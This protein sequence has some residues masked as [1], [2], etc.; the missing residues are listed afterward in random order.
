MS[1]KDATRGSSIGF[2]ACVNSGSSRPSAQSSIIDVSQGRV[3]I[4]T[5][6]SEG[7]EFS[8][9][10]AYGK[11]YSVHDLYDGSVARIVKTLA[12]GR[13]A[14]ILALGSSSSEKTSMV[15]RLLPQIV[16]GLYAKMEERRNQSSSSQPTRRDRRRG[17]SGASRC[18]MR[19]SAIE[20]NDEVIQD[21]LSTSN[22]ELITTLD[23]TFGRV[24][25]NVTQQGPTS[26]TDEIMESVTEATRARS[27]GH[28]V[29]RIDVLLE[30]GRADSES[31]TSFRV[32]LLVCD[33]AGTEKLVED[34]STLRLKE[35]VRLNKSLFALSNV[36]DIMADGGADSAPCRE[37]KLTHVI[38]EALGGNFDTTCIAFLDSGQYHESLATMQLGSTLHRSVTYPICNNAAAQG[39]LRRYR[40][41]LS[42]KGAD[43][44]I[45]GNYEESEFN[46]KLSELEGKAVKDKLEILKLREDKSRIVEKLKDFQDRYK[47]LNDSKR[48]VQR[49]LIDSEEENL[50]TSNALLDMQIENNQLVERSEAEKYELLSKIMNAENEILELVSKEQKR[51]EGAEK[52]KNQYETLEQQKIG[53]QQDFLALQANF[54]RVDQDLKAE[55]KKNEELGL[56]LLTLV[57]QRNALSTECE[58]LKK[59]KQAFESE[60]EKL[61]G[62]FTSRQDE[63]AEVKRK[64]KEE[65][66]V[67]ETLRSEKIKA[68]LELQ[69][70]M[71]EYDSKKLEL[72]KNA[73]DFTR[74]RDSE[75]VGL[76]KAV[77]VEG[78]K[79]EA[80]RESLHKEV[81][82]LKAGSRKLSRTIDTLQSKLAGR[83]AELNRLVGE[84][85]ELEQKLKGITEDYQSKLIQYMNDPANSGDG[86]EFDDTEQRRLR[87]DLVQSFKRQQAE[88]EAKSQVLHGENQSLIAKN[89]ALV[90]RA[91]E[92]RNMLEDNNVKVQNE[93][94]VD[95]LK[96]G[97]GEAE[98]EWQRE[99]S[100]LIEKLRR[101]E[102]DLTL[103]KEKVIA[104]AEQGRRMVKGL[105][106]KNQELRRDMKLLEKSKQALEQDNEMLALNRGGGGT[107]I[108]LKTVR[109]L[110]AMMSEM[111]TSMRTPN[112]SEER[113]VLGLK[114]KLR[115][116]ELEIESL[117]RMGGGGAAIP[118]GEGA[119]QKRIAELLSQNAVL[120]GELEHYEKYMKNEV[121]KMKRV[122]RE[123][124]FWRQ[125]AIQLGATGAE[126]AQ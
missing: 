96:V 13:S 79:G 77:E 21:L 46:L 88:L 60:N 37:S 22:R 71:I 65:R 121:E 25:R 63:L 11:G 35:G 57:N 9:N 18:S 106:N 50:K 48:S 107:G 23:E 2:V 52:L 105:E 17:R 27:S 43:G 84:N 34:P 89:R 40:R 53:L 56:E 83:T 94:D 67:S 39:L 5:P 14:C 112:G 44:D 113:E 16:R 109:E 69:R 6:S 85:A 92:L 38:E 101:A 74:D 117:R 91:K 3:V 66:G 4:R 98:T 75:V 93:V 126:F 125:K 119:S 118:G 108:P 86:G 30:L 97:V 19:F 82:Q 28:A 124:E 90:E 110:Q 111:K 116:A 120:K 78:K 55:L 54:V 51:D 41:K 47:D 115:Q 45:D 1:D 42:Q 32:S 15:H 73:S 64:L 10:E 81:K 33:V 8:C 99:R 72:E 70:A 24:V 123:C 49:K 36:A 104:T 76:R 95:K 7:E 20:I 100:H 29:F 114:S 26:D 31:D 59:Q 102:S 12:S 61:E 103:S 80:I 58:E 68:E 87:E 122:A 62:G